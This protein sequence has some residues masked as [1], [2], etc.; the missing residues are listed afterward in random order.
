L[1]LFL[2]PGKH[3]TTEKKKNARFCKK[4]SY[5]LRHHADKNKNKIKRREKCFEMNSSHD[6]LLLPP[7]RTFS[8]FPPPPHDP[9]P[10]NVLIHSNSPP[11]TH[12]LHEQRKLRKNEKRK[13]SYC[14]SPTPKKKAWQSTVTDLV[15]LRGKKQVNSLEYI[16]KRRTYKK[17]M[18]TLTKANKR[19]DKACRSAYSEAF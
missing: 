5:R 17:N 8:L 9:R 19:R 14:E 6:H 1:F 4:G 2:S 3:T 13:Q 18:K 12:G 7:K 11:K 16:K 15:K 10:G